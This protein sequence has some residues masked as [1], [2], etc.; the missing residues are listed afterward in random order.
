MSQT[1]TPEDLSD[2][3]RRMLRYIRAY[4]RRHGF[5]PSVRDLAASCDTSTSV[6]AYN[7]ERLEARGIIRRAPRIARG[8]V[9]V[10]EPQEVST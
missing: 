7:L 8:I 2:R 10:E 1:L 4:I 5:A 9:L 3:Q 6:I